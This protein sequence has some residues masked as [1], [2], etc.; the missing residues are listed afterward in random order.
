MEINKALCV[1]RDLMDYHDLKDWKLESYQRRSSLG[2]CRIWAK[3][4]LLS[5][6]YIEVNDLEVIVDVVLHE[7]AHALTRRGHDDV[8]REKCKELNCCPSSTYKGELHSPK[9]LWVAHCPCGKVFHR[10]RRCNATCRSCG[11]KVHW[12]RNI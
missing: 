2:T 7:I 10:N 5:V 11:A 4:I 3:K 12:K 1:A 9:P 8:F 6:H